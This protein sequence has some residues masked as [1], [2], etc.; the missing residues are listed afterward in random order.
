MQQAGA[1]TPLAGSAEGENA[2]TYIDGFITPVPRDKKD[3]YLDWTRATGSAFI[4]LGARRIL[5]SWEDDLAYDTVSDF[6]RAL[7]AHDDESIVFSWIEW[8]DKQTR[9]EAW[10]KVREP[11]RSDTDATPPMPIEPM[12]VIYGGFA[13]ILTL[14][15]PNPR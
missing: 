4:E 7:Q 2:M 8:P 11:A 13:P 6:R 12:R 14:E 5:E 15:T 3:Q 1:G 9:D 10:A